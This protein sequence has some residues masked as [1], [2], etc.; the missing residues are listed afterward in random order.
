[1]MTHLCQ[2][3]VVRNSKAHKGSVLGMNPYTVNKWFWLRLQVVCDSCCFLYL[4]VPMRHLCVS[5]ELWHQMSSRNW[6]TANQLVVAVTDQICQTILE[7]AVQHMIIGT[8]PGWVCCVQ[9]CAYVCRT[10]LAV[11]WVSCHLQF[12]SA[13]QRPSLDNVWFLKFQHTI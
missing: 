5:I 1:M 8:P 12:K 9:R 10:I 2:D 13:Y 3:A 6:I 7:L 4:W 11:Q